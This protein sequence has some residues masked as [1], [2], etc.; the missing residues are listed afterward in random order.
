L[1][2]R[3]ALQ[4]TLTAGITGWSRVA[5]YQNPAA[6]KVTIN[7]R[8]ALKVGSGGEEHHKDDR[9]RP[10]Y[11]LGAS[12]KVK[13]NGEYVAREG[14]PVSDGDVISGDGAS[15]NVTFG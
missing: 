12:G 5:L 2:K 1:G 8:R 6:A 11:V 7:G 14:D 10:C 3:V 9:D 13:I 15:S 4:G